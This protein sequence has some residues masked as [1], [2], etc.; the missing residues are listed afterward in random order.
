MGETS[1]ATARQVHTDWRPTGY[2][3]DSVRFPVDQVRVN[4][5]GLARDSGAEGSGRVRKGRLAELLIA[6]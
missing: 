5:D 6:N 1:L 2:K 4:E 3:S